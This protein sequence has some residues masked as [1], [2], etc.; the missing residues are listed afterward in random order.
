MSTKSQYAEGYEYARDMEDKLTTDFI[1]TEI[2]RVAEALRTGLDND[3]APFRAGL[4]A[5]YAEA[6]RFAVVNNS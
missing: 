3:L 5:G 6:V 2:S 1:L 4:L